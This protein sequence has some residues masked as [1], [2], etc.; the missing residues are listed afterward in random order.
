MRII[1]QNIWRVLVRELRMMFA[2]P[3]YLF[4]SVGVMLLSTF[5]FLT[6]MKGGAAE[7]MPMAVVDQDQTTISRRLIHEMQ[8][9]P[10]VD[11]QLI[12]N[13]YSEARDAMQKGKIYGFRGSFKE[14]NNNVSFS[15]DTIY[16]DPSQMKPLSPHK[17]FIEMDAQSGS[18]NSV[19]EIRSI[20]RS[21]RGTAEVLFIIY[22]G[23][24]E[25]GNKEGPARRIA[26]GSDF[27]VSADSE[28]EKAIRECQ[29]VLD[30]YS[31]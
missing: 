3:L 25:E 9:T 14:Y 27:S 11:I 28:M 6:L 23:L 29:G 2:R 1:L 10:S 18:R 30:V 20:C 24:D 22:K 21:H 13:S 8:A 15:A 31:E 19:S 17:L 4:A 12:T 7:K 26:A 5:F 16:P